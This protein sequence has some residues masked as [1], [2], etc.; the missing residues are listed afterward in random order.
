MAQRMHT[1][2]IEWIDGDVDD[3]DE[4]SVFADSENDAISKARAKWRVTIGA[5]W[6]HCRIV[7][8]KILPKDLVKKL[9]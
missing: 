5:E 1:V 9:A 3:V 6:P 2:L 7:A 8:S 4:I